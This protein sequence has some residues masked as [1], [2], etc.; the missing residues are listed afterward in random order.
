[1]KEV[2]LNPSDICRLL[3]IASGTFGT[4]EFTHVPESIKKGEDV[5]DAPDSLFWESS[6][7]C[8][9]FFPKLAHRHA[10]DPSEATNESDLQKRV[11]GFEQVCSIVG[12]SHEDE[13]VAIRVIL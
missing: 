2:S 4:Y 3:K 5:T 9:C 6:A 13:V 7:F 8:V 12:C 1:M 11:S 10:T